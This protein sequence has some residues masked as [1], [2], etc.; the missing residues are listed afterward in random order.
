MDAVRFMDTVGLDEET[1]IGI[2]KA[3]NGRIESG[4]FS[5]AGFDISEVDIHLLGL[6]G[7]DG[8]PDRTAAVCARFVKTL[9]GCE[10]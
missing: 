8:E 7:P 4:R 10:K 1:I 3:I 5:P 2:A 9:L 6:E